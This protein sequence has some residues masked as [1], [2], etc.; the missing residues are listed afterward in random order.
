MRI[1]RRNVAWLTTIGALVLVAVLSGVAS[2]SVSAALVVLFVGALLA[3]LLEPRKLAEMPR[4]SLARM[5]M[6]AQAQ[7]ASGRAARRGGYQSPDLNLLDIGL[8][9]TQSNPEGMVM[10]KT[11]AVSLDDDGVRPFITLHVQPGIADT[12][13][14]LRFEILDPNG[15]TQYVHEMK[16]YLRDGEMNI[17]TD[18]QL[19]LFDN[20][21]LAVTGDCDL[22]VYLDGALLG[23][24]SFSLAPSVQE[25]RRQFQRAAA[26]ESRRLA[27]AEDDEES[28]LSLED[29]LRSRSSR[30][31]R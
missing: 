14:I 7:E 8:I 9:A 21:R 4:S 20:D 15:Q 17:L 22:R 25:R 1:R 11:R 12:N 30:G 19:P 10:R 6:S 3:S 27:E 31:G 24:L 28:S 2:P 16:T 26:P 5:R 29:L 18:H 13:A 23:M